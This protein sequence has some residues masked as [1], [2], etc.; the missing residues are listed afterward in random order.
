MT[1]GERIRAAREA[2]QMTQADAAAAYGCSRPRWAEIEAGRFPPQV[3][4]LRRAARVVG[5]S[6]AD[7]FARGTS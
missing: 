4:T 6:L 2:R 3:E 1:P 5:L 7:L